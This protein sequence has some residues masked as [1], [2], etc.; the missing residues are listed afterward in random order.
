MTTPPTD[1]LASGGHDFFFFNIFTFFLQKC[2]GGGF[3]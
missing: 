3:I 2:A 1:S